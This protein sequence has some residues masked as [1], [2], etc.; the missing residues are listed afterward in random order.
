MRSMIR[1]F[2]LSLVGA[3][4]ACASTPAPAPA[5]APMVVTP[6]PAPAPAPAPVA[7]TE[8]QLQGGHITLQHQIT[9][10]Y[11]S[12]HIQESQSQTVLNDLIALMRENTQIR[13]VRVE[14]HTDVRGSASHNQELSERRAQAVAA[15]LRGHGFANIQF[16]A[17]GYGQTQPLCRDD[18][19]ACHDRNRRVEFTI[20]EPA[21]TP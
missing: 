14:G 18:N 21:A 9:F 10:D 3:L 5:P 19:D 13:R 6:A 2:A 1:P 15:Y 7:H 11:D 20:T 4:A 16:E 12:D 17:V 8:A